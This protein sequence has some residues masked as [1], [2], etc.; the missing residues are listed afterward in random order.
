MAF[1]GVDHGKVLGQGPGM[2]FP[3]VDRGKVLRQ[4]GQAEPGSEHLWLRERTA[5]TGEMTEAR[6]RLDRTAVSQ[7]GPLDGIL[8]IPC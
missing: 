3:S 8:S 7:R 6:L 5:G 4:R 1:P 2:A